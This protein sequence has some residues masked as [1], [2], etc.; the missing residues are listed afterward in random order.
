MGTLRYPILPLS[1]DPAILILDS[2]EK[3]VTNCPSLPGLG[4]LPKT[5]LFQG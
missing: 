2:I 5:W 4:G 3:R 1:P